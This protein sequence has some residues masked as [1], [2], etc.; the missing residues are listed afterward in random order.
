M[1]TK[2]KGLW[3]KTKPSLATLLCVAFL[4]SCPMMG[5]QGADVATA[6]HA[7]TADTATKATES[8]HATKADT[9]ET[10]KTAEKAEKLDYVNVS[11]SSGTNTADT[12]GA[13]GSK[14]IAI[15]QDA[16]ADGQ[17]GIAIGNGAVAGKRG[18]GDSQGTNGMNSIT[19][20]AAKTAGSEVLSIGTIKYINS[21]YGRVNA[22]GTID[23]TKAIPTS[24]DPVPFMGK[25]ILM[26]YDNAFDANNKDALTK[27][28]TTF[29]YRSALIGHE[30]TIKS[31][32]VA[33]GWS[34]G[35]MDM[36]IFGRANT[37]DGENSLVLGRENDVRRM[38]T[39]PNGYVNI[40]G[41]KNIIRNYGNGLH[42]SGNNNRINHYKKSIWYGGDKSD[43]ENDFDASYN[44]GIHIYGARNTLGLDLDGRHVLDGFIVGVNNRLYSYNGYVF[45]SY[46]NVYANGATVFGRGNLVGING[47][48]LAAGTDFLAVGL[49]N[50][51]RA[52]YGMGFGASNT[53]ESEGGSAF[54]RYNKIGPSASYSTVMG[55][56]NF[57]SKGNNVVFGIQNNNDK[58]SGFNK[59]VPSGKNSTAIGI[60][61]QSQGERST[62]LGIGNKINENGKNAVALGSS[63]VASNEE[64]T[65]VGR[66]NVANNKKAVAVGSWNNYTAISG[67][68]KVYNSG[69]ESVAMGV[70]NMSVGNYSTAVGNLNMTNGLASAAVGYKNA[71]NGKA[72][73][74]LGY[75]NIA[76]G[77]NG[78][79]ETYITAV[80]VNNQAFGKQNS[81]F[82]AYNQANV[83][84]GMIAG[85]QN[86]GM[87]YG[88]IIVGNQNNYLFSDSFTISGIT[89][90]GPDQPA[91]TGILSTTMG[92]ANLML[93]DNGGTYGYGNQITGRR[94]YAFG[95]TNINTG[96]DSFIMGHDSTIA[97]AQLSHYQ[98][99]AQQN[100]R[101]AMVVGNHSLANISDSVALG[102]YAITTRDYGMRGYDPTTG[103]GMTDDALFTGTM[104]KDAY[105]QAKTDLA[106]LRTTLEGEV[107][108]LHE[109]RLKIQSQQYSS[110]DEY[111]VLRTEYDN[112]ENVEMNARKAYL[113]KKME[114]GK[115]AGTWEGQLAALSIGNE[116]IGLTRQITGVAAGT[117]DTDAVNVAQLKRL[118]DMVDG[119]VTDIDDKIKNA[120]TVKVVAGTNTTVTESKDGDTTTYA[121]NV[122]LT[123]YAKAD[124]SNI[125][126]INQ[127]KQKLGITD[128]APVAAGPI[129]YKADGD[130]DKKTV[131]LEDGFVFTGD[132]NVKASTGA[133]G[134]VKYTLAKD[135]TGMNSI[136]GH[137]GKLSFTDDGVTLSHEKDGASSSISVGKEVRLK[138]GDT[139]VKVTEKGLDA[140][141]KRI[142]HV[143]DGVAMDDAATVGQLQGSTAGIRQEIGRV[144]HHLKKEIA[145]VGA[146]GAAM[147]ALKPLGYNPAEK[148]QIMAGIGGYKG[149]QGVALGL[150][151]HDNEDVLYHGGLAYSGNGLMWNAGVSIRFGKG[152]Q[153]KAYGLHNTSTVDTSNMATKEEWMQYQSTLKDMEASLLHLRK[154][155]DTLRKENE[156]LA[157]KVEWLMER[158]K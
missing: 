48:T 49:G 110:Q 56:E 7:T 41:D 109:L 130:A 39:G 111:N 134:E 8:D 114:M 144:E 24:N 94:S 25:V 135:L 124:G 55:H 137:D 16:R 107:D 120:K 12:S 132:D 20:G 106:G 138:A 103:A 128:V 32:S 149:S 69:Q 45:G 78:P 90:V 126:N 158:V 19:I 58:S 84:R 76:G 146:L 35:T 125:T 154:E 31:N 23:T 13:V 139:T 117:K 91:N 38:G 82:G 53:I 51:V 98:P 18:R 54:G 21:L 96:I 44:T 102:A 108:K 26:G 10:A 131:S 136:G 42:I 122:D 73:V 121:V 148:T 34:Y 155:N 75:G 79:S 113:G 2:G 95:A 1:N 67:E 37:I 150:A 4:T 115:A 70:K 59:E 152:G 127:W 143:A 119:K 104:T 105:N 66:G 112:Q 5:I 81:V 63:N 142:S 65:A 30:N 100:I 93:A 87:G 28:S 147:S 118:A 86:I 141:G 68:W 46:N 52:N 153:Q 151:H 64:A 80:G 61:N 77:D 9:A 74:A 116:E 29:L 33:P 89:M 133:N 123:G 145:D 50:D 6:D 140:G 99:N 129:S 83:I 57:A 85:Y 22:D 101:D 47:D 92:V 11:G 72:D 60:M 40:T 157:K 36:Y 17:N 43:V 88:S 3:S 27:D 62:T 71:A 97:S 156:D 14:S 15:G